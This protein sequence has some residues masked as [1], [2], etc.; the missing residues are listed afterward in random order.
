MSA[1]LVRPAA[2]A[3]LALVTLAALPGAAGGQ[4]IADAVRRTRDGQ[5]RASFTLRPGVCGWGSNISTT[6]SRRSRVRFNDSDRSWSRDVEYDID[7][8]DGP[9]R[10]VL[11]VDDGEVRSLRFYVGGRWRPSTSATDVGMV[12]TRDAA[13]YLLTLARTHNGRAGKEAVFPATLVDSVEVW[14]ELMKLA[15]DEN[16]PRET[17]KN[18]VF[19]L[20]QLAE[21]PATRGLD[22][23]VGEEAVDR[24][25]RE[26]AI[27]AL[28]QRPHDEGVPALIKVVKSNRDPELRKKALFWLGQSG[29]PRALDLIEELLAKR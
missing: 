29:D 24:E 13:N 4:S 20:G 25:V 15:R 12:N 2:V 26:S 5:V 8:D 16:R 28:S 21:E 7:C 14:P 1:K 22:E 10:L 23:L 11:D 3:A 17:R 18:A 6:G 19:W 9:G 27:F